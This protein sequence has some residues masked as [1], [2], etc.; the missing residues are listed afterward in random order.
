MVSQLTKPVVQDI[1]TIPMPTDAVPDKP[2]TTMS[3]PSLPLLKLSTIMAEAKNNASPFAKGSEDGEIVD[4]TEVD[5]YKDDSTSSILT[6]HE[7]SSDSKVLSK[8]A[9]LAR[10]Q[11]K[12]NV[13]Y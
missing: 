6:P 13:R 1:A 9:A 5:T 3:I 10:D 11:F 8:D 2:V 7:R 4:H 12:H